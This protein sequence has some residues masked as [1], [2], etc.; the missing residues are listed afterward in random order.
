[1]SCVLLCAPQ[2]FH[3]VNKY[4]VYFGTTANFA[5]LSGT[6]ITDSPTSTIT[7]DV[8]LSPAT[9]ASID[10]LSTQVTGTIYAVDT[11]GPVN[12]ENNPGKLTTAKNDLGTAYD[13]AAGRSVT[14]TIATEL[15]GQTLIDGV[16]NSASTTFEI[17]SGAGAL[18]LDGQGNADSV[19]IFQMDS[20]ATGLTVGPGSTVSLINGA[21]A[22]NVFWKV[23]TATIDTTATFKG[24]ILANTSITF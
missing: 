17:T 1:M 10:L 4:E 24:T 3:I 12:S 14:A 21:S 6:E 22:C 15:G 5:I 2:N 9:G 7:G 11:A 8:G 18:V 19:F 20:G 16:Y 13:D 23:N